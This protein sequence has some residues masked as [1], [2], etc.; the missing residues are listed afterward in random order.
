MID[1]IKKDAYLKIDWN[2]LLRKDKGDHSLKEAKPTLD[3]IKNLFENIFGY[4]GVDNL[5]DNFTVT[6]N[7]E[8][9][10][11]IDLEGEI[12]NN[13]TDDSQRENILYRIK[14]LEYTIF[15]NLSPISNYIEKSDPNIN[16]EFKEQEHVFKEKIKKITA[17][18]NTIENLLKRS[19]KLATNT[20]ISEYGNFF[21][22]QAEKN[23]K[24][25]NASFFLMIFFICM[26]IVFCLVFLRDISLLPE[27]GKLNL[28]NFLNIIN[29]QNLLVKFIIISTLGY[30]V[31]YF[32]KVFS[33]ERHLYYINIQRQNALDS[34]KQILDSVIATESENEKEI[35]NAI[36]LELTKAIFEN[37][38]TGYLKSSQNSTPINQVV[39]ISRIIKK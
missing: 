39:D 26:I 24:I 6:I 32:S 25:G 3:R 19:K 12:I 1:K 29:N 4:P 36:L 33:S 21:G 20:E 13:F 17:D 34:H 10:K 31:S 9:Q 38:D 5:H 14:D 8:M 7:T 11:M 22:K 28:K 35:R 27:A 30:L 18:Q 37:K 16:K 15:I 2:K 23:W